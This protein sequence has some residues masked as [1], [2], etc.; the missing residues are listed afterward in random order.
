M[1]AGTNESN[2][3]INRGGYGCGHQFMPVSTESVPLEY[4]NKIKN[5]VFVQP[6]RK[7]TPL[8][9]KQ[10]DKIE[11]DKSLKGKD[12]ILQEKSI[13]KVVLEQK[14][15]VNNY[16]KNNGN[17]INT[18]E[19]R[20]EFIDIGYNGTNASAVHEAS[21]FLSKKALEKL[22][23]KGKNNKVSFYAG[24]AGSCKTSTIETLIPDIKSTSDAIIDGNLS[25]YEKAIKKF[26]EYLQ[27][28]KN[29]EVAY[30]Y[31]DPLD[32]WDAVIKRMLN[33]KSEM[34]RAVKSSTFIE[35]TTGSYKTAKQILLSELMQDP[36]FKIGI[37]DNSLGKGNAK[38]MDLE[39]FN[40]IKF[41]SDL[42]IQLRIITDD[43][44]KK[45]LITQEQYDIL[46]Q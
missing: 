28:S 6:S 2:L 22:I 43:Y 3:T 13:E 32:A 7:I 37:F 44:L 36:K 5:G 30:V 15:L 16:L 41:P 25:N 26:D 9:Q 40:N 14:K 4:R 17:V 12:I 23:D 46:I 33:N 34:G 45:G 29:V 19:A 18:D 24:G 20:K 39:K 38:K 8:Q 10:I 27:K 42:N 31:R 11:R 21:S 1:E 35:N